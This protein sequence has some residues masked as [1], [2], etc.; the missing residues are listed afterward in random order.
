MGEK[1]QELADLV[2]KAYNNVHNPRF[3]IFR[4][5]LLLFYK[6]LN[7]DKDYIKILLGLRTDLL[8]ADLSLTIKNRITGLPTEYQAIYNFIEPQLKQVDSKLIDKYSHY[9]FIPLKF[10]STIKYF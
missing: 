10:G 6:E 2:D 9:G 1:R 7:S 3:N 8:Q 4:E 5:K